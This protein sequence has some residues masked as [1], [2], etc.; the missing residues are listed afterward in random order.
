MAGP[1]FHDV[2]NIEISEP[3]YGEGH[4]WSTIKITHRMSGYDADDNYTDVICVTEIACHHKGSVK[5]D[6]KVLGR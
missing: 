6:V 5:A 3:S 1:S 4:S 2:T